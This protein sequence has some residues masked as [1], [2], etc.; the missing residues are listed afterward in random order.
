MTLF[1][2]LNS[3][4]SPHAMTWMLP[5][6]CV[7]AAIALMFF[8]EK[9]TRRNLDQQGSNKSSGASNATANGH[10]HAHTPVPVARLQSVDY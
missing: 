10:A 4:I 7:I 1:F 9:N 5:I 6:C 3:V 2:A 8:E